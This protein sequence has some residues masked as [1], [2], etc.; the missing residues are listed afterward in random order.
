M[1]R[2]LTEHGYSNSPAL[3]GE[4]VRVDGDGTPQTLII[5][6][7]F[8]RNQGD[9]WQWTL[10]KV[11]LAIHA[12]A[13]AGT[14]D[15]VGREAIAT[16][17]SFA[18]VIGKR[19]GEL[20]AVLA[21]PTDD[22]AFM[23]ERVDADETTA[24]AKAASLEVDRA[25]QTLQ[26]FT[27]WKDDAEHAAAKE[28]ITLRDPLGDKIREL[29]EAGVGT[30]RTR[31]HGDFHLGQILVSGDD[32]ILIDFEGEPSKSLAERRAKGSPLRDVAGLL[33]SFDYAA[34]TIA[35]E[36][37]PAGPPTADR[38]D[39]LLAHFVTTASASFLEGYRKAAVAAQHKWV[40]NIRYA[41]ALI[42][43]FLIE[44]AAYEIGYEAGNR[45]TWIGIPLR[46][47]NMLA[48]RLLTRR[49]RVDA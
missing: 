7:R 21:K 12:G 45:P 31:L 25:L 4:M 42:E 44:K 39:E 26:K 34:A 8:V 20:H 48:K 43:L 16:Y 29:A 17:Q 2:Y 11:R 18:A 3:F 10:D 13:F 33:R 27:A 40:P 37:A 38:R 32:A 5:A 23:P 22:P 28:L 46:G 6:E 49:E 19:L 41:K 24:W 1:T 15:E 30:L 35:R 14:E 9:A 47:L 36:P